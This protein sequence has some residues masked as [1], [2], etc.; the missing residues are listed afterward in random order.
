LYTGERVKRFPAVSL[1][2][3]VACAQS[4]DVGLSRD[5]RV[6]EALSIRAR[7]A[8]A[9]TVVLLG[10]V[11]AGAF[12]QREAET[13][14]ALPAARRRFHLLAIPNPSPSGARLLFPPEGVA[15][16]NNPESHYLWRWIATV[17][18]DLVLIAGADD[19]GLASAL[20]DIPA[21]TI[22]MRPGV[23]RRL[24]PPPRSAAARELESRL[25]RTPKQVA[26]ELARHYGH[27]L[28]QAVYIP[29][30]AL[31]GRLRLG[32]ADDVQRI[33][34][35]FAA[36]EKDS[37][38]RATAS[39]LS[40]HLV[41]GDLAE[42]TGDPKYVALVRKAAE[43]AVTAGARLHNEMSDSVFMTCPIL[44]KAGKLTG[45]R[46]YFDLA[47]EH[48]RFMQK[49]CLRSDGLYRHSPL[50]EAAWGRGNAFPALGLALALS[51]MPPEHAA[52]G[53][54]KQALVA[55]LAALARWQDESGMWRQVVDVRG[56]YRE[57][58]A[59][60]MIGTAMLR[61]IRRGWIDAAEYQP[62]VNAAWR[63]V[64][65]RVRDGRMIDV[66]E[67]T[68]KQASLEAYL[69]RAAILGEDARGG[70]MALLFATEMARLR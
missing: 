54:M 38:E 33:V 52:F 70:A 13:V 10:G 5:G 45:E 7:A 22:A 11:D 51:D 59:T 43:F 62:R 19:S 68:G 24:R 21:Q 55:H 25:A 26:D 3:A 39:H 64:L 15:Y 67:S 60:A 17:A 65:A 46:R 40:G 57:F 48:L 32:F 16:R 9:P 69:A 56:A 2:A 30:F 23:L 44:A 36:G 31:I 42:R 63:T 20:R 50:S 66:C 41:F 47:L 37:L 61:A 1:V 14:R 35:P 28:E 53:A 12:V 6:I 58:S 27:A 34:A 8:G 18:P 4:V 49:L 29:A